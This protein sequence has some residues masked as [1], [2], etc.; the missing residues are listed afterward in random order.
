MA[1]DASRARSGRGSAHTC[2]PHASSGSRYTAPVAGSVEVDLEPGPMHDELGFDV[3]DDAVGVRVLL[4]KPGVIVERDQR[5]DLR[6][7]VMAGVNGGR[8]ERLRAEGPAERF[9]HGHPRLRAARAF[10]MRNQR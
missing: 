8:N 5:G 3:L 1:R 2:S 4:A 7:Q 9:S 10:S 6:A